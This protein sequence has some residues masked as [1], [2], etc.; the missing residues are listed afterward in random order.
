LLV[1][2]RCAD[3]TAPIQEGFAR[4]VNLS[5]AGALL[6]LPDLYKIGNEFELEFLLDNNFIAPV[7]GKVV[8]IN[9]RKD[10][11]EVAIAFAK[12]PAKIKH[13]FE[14]QTQGS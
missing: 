2:F 5:D 10:F 11:Y 4:A 14:E 7:K 6:E 9:K 3:P 1:A 8:R 13:K 12:V